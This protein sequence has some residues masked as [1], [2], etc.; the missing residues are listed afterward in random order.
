MQT[1]DQV[2]A[3]A[4]RDFRTVA[5]LADAD[6][7]ADCIAVQIFRKPHESPKTLPDGNIAVYAFFHN[8]QALKV[9]KAGPNSKARYTSQHYSTGAATSTLARSIVNNA[10]KIG[11]SEVHEG[12]VAAWIRS[13]TDR[14][15]LL[16]PSAV[17]DPMLS[18]LESFLHV[19][20]KPIFE[21]RG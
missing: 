12:I 19:R 13:N 21:G 11:I 20:W 10:A 1:L 16:L 18:L 14:V 8:G 5:T 9:G 17:G 6:F 15:N 4:L 2:V 7:L 3:N